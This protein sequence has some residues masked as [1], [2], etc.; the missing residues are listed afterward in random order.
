MNCFVL[1]K[2][3]FFLCPLRFTYSFF[4]ALV[5]SSYKIPPNPI[6]L[7]SIFL[8]YDYDYDC[9]GYLQWCIYWHVTGVK[10][11][12]MSIKIRYEYDHSAQRQALC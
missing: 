7:V 1:L 6:N 10:D 2:F 8:H 12:N 11:V 3:S 5:I 9:C 4:L